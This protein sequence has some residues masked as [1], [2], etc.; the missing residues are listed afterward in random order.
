MNLS[1][2]V[3]AGLTLHPSTPIQAV[4]INVGANFKTTPITRNRRV[5]S[6]PE[7]FVGNL[8]PVNLPRGEPSLEVE[9]NG[10]EGI[11]ARQTSD[12]APSIL[13]D[14]HGRAGSDA[15]TK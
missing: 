11:T 12:H 4:K 8:Q 6:S 2:L 15:V 14:E 10:S 7:R 5:E 3:D 1:V 13:P 9:Q